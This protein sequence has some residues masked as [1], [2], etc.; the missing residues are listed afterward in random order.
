MYQLWRANRKDAWAQMGTTT[1]TTANSAQHATCVY[2]WLLAT[3][4]I[5]ILMHQRRYR[6]AIVSPIATLT[7]NAK[8]RGNTC[9][10]CMVQHNELLYRYSIATYYS[11]ATLA[12][13]GCVGQDDG[14]KRPTDMPGCLR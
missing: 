8:D 6:I 1:T 4:V 2:A 5:G 7:S 11:I 3:M 13:K 9:T 12:L 14:V 10:A